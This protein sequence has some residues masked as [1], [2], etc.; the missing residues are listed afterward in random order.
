MQLLKSHTAGSVCYSPFKVCWNRAFC[1][2]FSLKAKDTLKTAESQHLLLMEESRKG[3]VKKKK[4]RTRM[5]KE[6]K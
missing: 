5:I 6:L 2:F 4:V 3:L 1:L